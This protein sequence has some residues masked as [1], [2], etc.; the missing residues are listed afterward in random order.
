MMTVGAGPRFVL[1]LTGS[2][3]KTG[4]VGAALV[5]VGATP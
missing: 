5:L 4:L 3:A 1:E 2:P